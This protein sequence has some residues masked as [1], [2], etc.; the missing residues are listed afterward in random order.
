MTDKQRNND[1]ELVE[2]HKVWGP[3]EMEVIKSMLNSHDIFCMTRGQVPQSILPM[4][5]DG[6]GEIKILVPK[7]DADLAKKLIK[8]ALDK[9]RS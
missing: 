4:T 8:D 7:K 2:I 3:A 1:L 9:N 5:T 6:M